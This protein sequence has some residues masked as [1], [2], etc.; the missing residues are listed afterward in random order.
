MLQEQIKVNVFISHAF[1]P[2]LYSGPAHNKSQFAVRR[3]CLICLLVTRMHVG[4]SENRRSQERVKTKARAREGRKKKPAP[5]REE[6][7]CNS[8]GIIRL[9]LG[10][11]VFNASLQSSNHP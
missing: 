8:F 5:V 3:G 2:S 11:L 6:R 10:Q 1:H 4:R 7:A 9:V